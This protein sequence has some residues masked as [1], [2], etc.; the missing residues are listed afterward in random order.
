MTK[1]FPARQTIEE[2]IKTDTAARV[3]SRKGRVRVHDMIVD[4]R[5]QAPKTVVPRAVGVQVE[6][7]FLH[8]FDLQRAA[9]GGAAG[10]PSLLDAAEAAPRQVPPRLGRAPGESPAS[11]GGSRGA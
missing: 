2:R 11:A 9:G 6:C 5:M 8:V 7:L 4:Y 3:L 1:C 10:K